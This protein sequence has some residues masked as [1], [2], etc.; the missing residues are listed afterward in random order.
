MKAFEAVNIKPLGNKHPG[1]WKSENRGDNII[2][3]LVPCTTLG[4]MLQVRC[5]DSAENYL[6]EHEIQYER[7]GNEMTQR[8]LK[9]LDPSFRRPLISDCQKK[10][11]PIFIGVKDLV[12]L[13]ML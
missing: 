2:Y 12:L 6:N 11:H 5:I 1:L 9:V 4:L 7:L 3:R 8:E 10:K 13:S